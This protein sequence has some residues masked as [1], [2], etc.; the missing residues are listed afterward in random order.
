M[1]PTSIKMYDKFGLILRIETTTNDVRFFKHYREVEHRDETCTLKWAEMKKGIYRLPAL[2]VFMTAANR[3]YVEFI[4]SLDDSSVGVR[5]LNKISQ[6]IVDNDRACRGFN[7]FD[8]DDQALFE[9]LARGEFNICGLRNRDLRRYLQF[10]TCAQ[11]SGI[12]KHLRVHG[13]LKRAGSSYK[14]Y[15]TRLGRLVLLAGLK[16]KK[17][18]IIPQLA[19]EPAWLRS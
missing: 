17:L 3:R 6:T 19:S 13:L 18:F 12:F 16:L 1:G 8:D 10:K 15:L 7:F 11:A 5:H 14:Y 2:R 4:S 9:I